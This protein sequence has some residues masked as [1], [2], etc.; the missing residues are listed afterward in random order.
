M[1]H[2]YAIEYMYDGAA[3]DGDRLF[4]FDSKQERD[5]W[6]T[7]D[8]R[9]EPATTRLAGRRFNL[10]AFDTDKTLMMWHEVEDVDGGW[11]VFRR[12]VNPR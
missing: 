1:R 4:R 10:K 7:A 2:W 11:V 3:C 5:M 12:Y 8:D 6:C 9:R